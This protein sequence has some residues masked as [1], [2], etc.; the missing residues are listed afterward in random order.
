VATCAKVHFF[1]KCRPTSPLASS[2]VIR[3]SRTCIE[4][5]ENQ[6][7][8]VLLEQAKRPSVRRRRRSQD[9]DL[10]YGGAIREAVKPGIDVVEPDR[11]AFEP[12]DG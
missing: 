11:A 6:P 4:E 1:R 12:V 5:N 2:S 8:P 3:K 7:I 10:A 9:N